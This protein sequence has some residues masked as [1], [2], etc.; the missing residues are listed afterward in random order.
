V[1]YSACL[2]L[3][4]RFAK[5]TTIKQKLAVHDRGMSPFFL[6]SSFF[7]SSFLL[8]VPWG[9]FF[10]ILTSYLLDRYQDRTNDLSGLFRDIDDERVFGV[11]QRFELAA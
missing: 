3:I 5:E 2:T 9:F 11:F 8:D 10:L 4:A 1:D 7:N 6:N